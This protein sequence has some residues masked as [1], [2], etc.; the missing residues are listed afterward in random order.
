MRDTE[1]PRKIHQKIEKGGLERVSYG[2]GKKEREKK[3]KRK[4][5]RI[6]GQYLQSS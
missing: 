6:K 3:R 5:E 2:H 4:N 1:E